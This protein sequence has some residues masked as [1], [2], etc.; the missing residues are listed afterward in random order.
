MIFETELAV[1]ELLAS[2]LPMKYIEVLYSLIGR[3]WHRY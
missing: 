1:C 2:R 3:D